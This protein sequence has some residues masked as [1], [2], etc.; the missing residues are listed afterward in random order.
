MDL[1]LQA[2]ILYIRDNINEIMR[3]V[4]GENDHLQDLAIRLN[5]EQ[6]V[7]RGVDSNSKQLGTYAKSY[8]QVRQAAGLQT[9]FI[10]LKFTGKFQDDFIIEDATGD[11]IFSINS[12]NWKRDILVERLRHRPGFGEDIFGLTKENLEILKDAMAPYI[13]LKINAILNA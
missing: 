10:D 2:K 6:L 7:N 4:L 9:G 11:I 3:D 12:E 5:K 13:K 8:S 1:R